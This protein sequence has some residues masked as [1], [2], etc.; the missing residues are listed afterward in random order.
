MDVRKRKHNENEGRVESGNW[1]PKAI[2][3]SARNLADTDAP[4]NVSS[5]PRNGIALS[6]QVDTCHRGL[7]QRQA[8]VA[9]CVR[10]PGV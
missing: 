3:D 9:V 2:A 8:A 6:P 5:R 4:R 10:N 1:R 7:P